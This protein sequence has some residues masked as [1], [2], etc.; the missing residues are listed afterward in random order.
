MVLGNLGTIVHELLEVSLNLSKFLQ[1]LV[2]SL[3]NICELGY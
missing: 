1:F 2:G 3:V